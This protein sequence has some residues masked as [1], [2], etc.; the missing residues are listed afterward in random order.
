MAFQLKNFTSILAS[1]VNWVRTSGTGLTDWSVGSPNRTLLEAPAAEM[2]Q[3]YQE[4]FHGIKE[5]IPVATYQ[6][7]NFGLLAP[8]RASGLLEFSVAAPAASNIPIPSGTPARSVATGIIYETSQA[9]T[10]LAGQTSVSVLAVAN[11]PGAEGNAASGTI[12]ELQ[13]SIPGVTV[14]NPN[15][16]QN[17]R[18]QET[19]A[20]RKVRFQGFISTLARGIVEAIRYGA[21]NTY[22]QDSNGL[23]T[24]RVVYAEVVEPYKTNPAGPIA[25]VLVYVHNGVGGTSNALIAETQRN[26]DGYR[27]PDGTPVVGWKAAGVVVEVY[28]AGEVLQD[29]IGELVLTAD[30]DPA[31]VLPEA[32]AVARDYLLS[33]T[34][35]AQCIR[36]EIVERVMSIDGVFDVILTDPSSNTAVQQDEKIMPGT[37]QFT[38]AS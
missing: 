2:D 22:L 35:G 20:E 7:F 27:R 6:S 15:V 26:L 38:E 18:D 34:V 16:F 24:E 36:H 12:T 11:V 4:F 13:V 32:E 19:E 30:A 29:V 3:L 8:V 37:I 10:I 17:G 25:L 23:I 28:A 21:E 31:V 33:L 9:A 5:A 1:M 14:T